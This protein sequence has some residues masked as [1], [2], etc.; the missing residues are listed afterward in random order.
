MGD[1]FDSP[2]IRMAEIAT[3]SNKKSFRL[4]RWLGIAAL[5]LLVFFV[6]FLAWLFQTTRSPFGTTNSLEPVHIEIA[7][8]HFAIPRAYIWDRTSWKGGEMD[9]VNMHALLPDFKPYSQETK[10]EFE[11]LGHGNTVGFLLKYSSHQL[12]RKQVFDRLY[13]KDAVSKGKE[14]PFGF[15]VFQIPTKGK[16]VGDDLH[17]RYL[18][19]GTFFY[20]ACSRIGTVVS[21]GCTGF[22]S[23]GDGFFVDYH[24]SRDYLKDWQ[25]IEQ[26]LRKLIH[27]FQVPTTISSTENKK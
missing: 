3:N 24:Y 17:F 20:L 22:M 6:G 25:Q 10:A 8:R 11:R 7:G 12:P 18:E 4:G 27:G 9:G 1:P 15:S 23:L 26:G 19:D 13:P 14:G 21:P 2:L 16:A 5:I